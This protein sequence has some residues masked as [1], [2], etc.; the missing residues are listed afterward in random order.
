MT[1]TII[2]GLGSRILGFHF[3]LYLYL[4]GTRLDQEHN[5]VWSDMPEYILEMFL[6]A[7]QTL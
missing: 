2:G 5:K 1:H 3:H 4:T 6:A 7:K